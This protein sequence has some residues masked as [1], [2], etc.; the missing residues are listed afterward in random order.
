MLLV[1]KIMSSYKYGTNPKAEM[2]IKTKKLSKQLA[3]HEPG[4]YYKIAG[5]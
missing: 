3:L 5:W 1:S 2:S 4:C